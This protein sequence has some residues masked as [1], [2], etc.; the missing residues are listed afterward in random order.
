MN[1]L[2]VFRNKKDVVYRLEISTKDVDTHSFISDNPETW[3]NI[4]ANIR[5]EFEKLINRKEK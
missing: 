3:Y 2:I 1:E 5:E 4:I